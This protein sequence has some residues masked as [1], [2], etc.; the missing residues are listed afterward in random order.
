MLAAG[1]VYLFYFDAVAQKKDPIVLLLDLPAPPPSNPLVKG[2]RGEREEKFYDK[3]NPPG[4]NAPIDELLDYWERQSTTYQALRYM[5]EPSE[6]TLDRLMKEIGK[7]HKIL[8]SYLNLLKREPEFVKGLYDHEGG[9]GV[10]DRE[11]RRTLKSWLTYNSSDFSSDLARLASAVSDTG[12]YVSNQE[13]LLALTHVDFDKA[14]PMIDRLYNDS[15]LKTS[16]VLARWALYKHA[17]ETGSTGDI[18]RYRDE[19]KVVVEDKTALAGMRDLALDALS[20][21][22]AATT[23]TTR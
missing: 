23:G 15:S 3:N 19:L 18:E 7:N 12:E 21:G 6:R 13:E 4:D 9:G 2:M 14:R 1:G 10:F 5:P 22:P 11:T 20:S 16:R 17:V 8:P